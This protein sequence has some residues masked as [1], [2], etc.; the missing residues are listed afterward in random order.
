M[1]DLRISLV[2]SPQFWEDKQRNFRHYETLLEGLEPT[3]ILVFPE[4]FHT[5][6]TMNAEEMAE[7]MDGQGIVWLTAQA[8]KW[9]TAVVASLIIQEEGH[10]YNRMVFIEPNGTIQMY[11]KR[12]LFTLAGE[13]KHYTAGKENTIVR[14]KEWKILL[15]VCYDLRF[16]EQCRNVLN[17]AGEP[18]YDVLLYVANWPKRRSVHWKTLLQARAIENQCYVVAVNRVGTDAN[19]L[20]YSG[21]SSVIDALGTLKVQ[22]AD[23]PGIYADSLSWKELQEVRE[24][25]AFLKDQ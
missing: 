2:Q 24:K 7:S 13:D 3:D 22:V 5:G 10:F 15:Q 21:D 8:K 19:D 12:K 4:M 14:Y 25:L 1:Q 17:S 16:P 20:E 11:D 9:N 23:E 18:T 6:F